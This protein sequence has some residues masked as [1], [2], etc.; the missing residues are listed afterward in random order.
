MTKN[1]L[2]TLVGEES[3][4]GYGIARFGSLLDNGSNYWLATAYSSTYLWRV[5]GGNSY[6]H[7][8]NYNSSNTSYGVRPVVSL[9]SG[10]RTSGRNISGVW[11]LE[12]P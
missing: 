1:D 3:T 7:G 4:H 11:K 12:E 8:F 10:I 2:D 6:V 5:D 9:V